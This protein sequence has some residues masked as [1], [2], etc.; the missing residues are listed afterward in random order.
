MV[1]DILFELEYLRS[2]WLFVNVC[3][4]VFRRMRMLRYYLININVR[5]FS[6]LDGND[7]SIWS[8]FLRKLYKFCKVL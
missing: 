8:C 2:L 7:E 1:W 6:L 3:Y 5:F 4:V